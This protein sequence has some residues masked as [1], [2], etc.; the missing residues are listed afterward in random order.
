MSEVQTSRSLARWAL[1]ALVAAGVLFAVYQG[2]LFGI[3]RHVDGL[4]EASVGS[5]IDFELR[6]LDGSVYRSVDLRGRTVVLNFFRSNCDRS[7]IEAPTIRELASKA[8][9]SQ[10]LLLGVMLDQVQG[11]DPAITRSTLELRSER[12][13]TA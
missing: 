2:V 1:L 11:Y 6:A 4:V 8:D 13:S 12:N 5:T 9:P 10:I 3:R 7:R